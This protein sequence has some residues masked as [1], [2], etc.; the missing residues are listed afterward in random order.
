MI[1]DI[2][3]VDHGGAAIS[4]EEYVARYY[5]TAGSTDARRPHRRCS[6][7]PMPGDAPNES[8]PT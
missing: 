7:R 3:H 4:Q 1:T 2:E 8:P 5:N 6:G